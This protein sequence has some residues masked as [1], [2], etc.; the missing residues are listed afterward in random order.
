MPS[1]S[2]PAAETLR[3]AIRAK[4]KAAVLRKNVFIINTMPPVPLIG[5]MNLQK[6]R[7]SVSGATLLTD[8]LEK[9]K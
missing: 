6:T 7:E 9:P 2:K 8:N 3:H 5:V 4:P 1:A